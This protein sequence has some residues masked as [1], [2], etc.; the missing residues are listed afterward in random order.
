VISIPT[1]QPLGVPSAYGSSRP[2]NVLMVLLGDY[3]S[4]RAVPVP[5]SMIVGLLAEFGFSEGSS[6]QTVRRLTERGHLVRTKDGRQTAYLLA[7]SRSADSERRRQIM[8]F[9]RDFEDWDRQWTVVSFSVPEKDRDSRRQLRVALGKLGMR[10]LNDGVWVSPH[11][12]TA[13]AGRLLDDLGID[14]AYILRASILER[15]GTTDSLASA[16]DLASLAERYTDF[17]AEYAPALENISAGMV[18]PAEALTYRTRLMADWLAFRFVD[19]VLPSELL[20]PGWPAHEARRIFSAVYDGLGATAE[21]RF[22]QVAQIA[23]PN[24]DLPVAH[25]RAADFG[26]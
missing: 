12:A 15:P 2:H 14:A 16:F 9:A 17:V 19:P 20:P 22:R 21:V 4:D 25:L 23:A 8:T 3:W 5:S 18:Y 13:Q 1:L 11:D 24:F 6:R 7:P 10:P 26:M